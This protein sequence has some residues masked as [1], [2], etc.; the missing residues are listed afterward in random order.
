MLNNG[1]IKG[2]NYVHY[3]T[4]ILNFIVFCILFIGCEGP[5]AI[6]EEIDVEEIFLT[7][8]PR[9]TEDDNGYYH[10]PMNTETWQTLH[11]FSGTVIQGGVPV[12]VMKI[13]WSSSHYW[14]IGDTLGYVVKKIFSHNSGNYVMVDTMYV[15]QF[16]GF[17]VPTINCCSYSNASGEVNSMF[18]PIKTMVGD[19][20]TIWA[21]YWDIYLELKEL[22]F[23]VILN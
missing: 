13:N 1:N 3:T 6:Q 5:N 11:R 23:N 22:E 8:N 10:L 2:K 16:N 18:A 12:D 14:Y 15:T 17:E 19:T 21:S 20:V 4:K 7:L 9:L